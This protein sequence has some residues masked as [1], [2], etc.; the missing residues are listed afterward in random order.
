LSPKEQ[1]NC[2]KRRRAATTPVS[3]KAAARRA[4]FAHVAPG[5]A[6]RDQHCRPVVRARPK[7]HRPG[8]ILFAQITT[9]M[10]E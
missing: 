9:D 5:G 2:G 1:A 4:T 6:H 8:R 7:P 3:K 10:W